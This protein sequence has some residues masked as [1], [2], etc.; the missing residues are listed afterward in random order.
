MK[1]AR[2]II[3]FLLAVCLMSISVSATSAVPAA[4]ETAMVQ[5]RFNY[6]IETSVG[7]AIGIDGRSVSDAGVTLYEST[8]SAKITLTLQRN[9]GSGWDDVKTWSVTD[10][11]P[12]IDI[13]EV[14]YVISGYEYRAVSVVRVYNA[15]NRIIEMTTEYSPVVEY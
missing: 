7:L 3:C 5:P 2:R 11:G 8:H 12:D 9:D 4:E 14:W 1:K 13:E 6:I 10:D 15:N